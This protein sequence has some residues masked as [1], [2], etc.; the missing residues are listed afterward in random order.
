[1]A[2]HKAYYKVP[3]SPSPSPSRVPLPAH[4]IEQDNVGDGELAAHRKA[5]L[6]WREPGAPSQFKDGRHAPC[7]GKQPPFTAAASMPD[8]E[9]FSRTWLQLEQKQRQHGGTSLRGGIGSV[10]LS[11]DRAVRAPCAS[12]PLPGGH[13]RLAP[14][15]RPSRPPVHPPCPASAQS[16]ARTAYVR[17]CS[18][19]EPPRAPGGSASTRPAP[20]QSVVGALH[21]EGREQ[22]MSGASRA[23]PGEGGLAGGGQLQL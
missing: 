6:R 15:V 18:C 4:Q 22:R 17:P 8:G 16:S 12:S 1:M 3:A 5:V 10:I 23:A 21:K 11:P 13:P 20:R 19:P 14:L 9:N 7:C 2:G